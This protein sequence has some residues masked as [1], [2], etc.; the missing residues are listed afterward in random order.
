MRRH[1]LD[2]ARVD[3]QL[4]V[5]YPALDCWG[6]AD[7]AVGAWRGQRQD[8]EADGR[9]AHQPLDR[10]ELVGVIVSHHAHLPGSGSPW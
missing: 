1:L 4:C 8:S 6:F 9:E 7:S 5:G 3:L 10:A 2:H